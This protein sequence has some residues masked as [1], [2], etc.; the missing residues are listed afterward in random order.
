[1]RLNQCGRQ[2][3]G[4]LV[5]RWHIVFEYRSIDIKELAVIDT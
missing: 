3:H 5:R 4:L 1:M 2:A